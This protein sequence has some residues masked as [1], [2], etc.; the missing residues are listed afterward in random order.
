MRGHHR[1][2]SGVHI[3]GSPFKIQMGGKE[4]GGGE[5]DTSLIKV[6]TRIDFELQF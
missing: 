4:L 5:P 3:P 1:F 2:L 6:S